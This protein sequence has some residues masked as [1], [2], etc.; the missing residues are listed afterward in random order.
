MQRRTPVEHLFTF[1]FRY[2]PTADPR[3]ADIVLMRDQMPK[4]EGRWNANGTVVIEEKRGL[5]WVQTDVTDLRGLLERYVCASPFVNVGG[6]VE[7]L[8]WQRRAWRESGW[9]V[10][11]NGRGVQRRL[12]VSRS[13]WSGV[14]VYPKAA[15]MAKAIRSELAHPDDV[16]M[17]VPVGVGAVSVV[18][19]RSDLL[20]VLRDASGSQ[21]VLELDQYWA[22]VGHANGVVVYP[23]GFNLPHMRGAR[24]YLRLD[25]QLTLERLRHVGSEF[26][27]LVPLG[28]VP[29]VLQMCAWRGLS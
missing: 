11:S 6:I 17:R 28:P 15:H 22:A 25:R 9:F 8:V 16:D 5:V 12:C 26:V 19:S 10:R 4:V 13:E 20:T 7:A 24:P 23:S 18:L 21:M 14:W 2:W 1:E 29:G 3:V 27:E